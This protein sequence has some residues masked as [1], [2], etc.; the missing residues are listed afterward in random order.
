MR[1]LSLLKKL[2]LTEQREIKPMDQGEDSG[3]RV[4]GFC[5]TAFDSAYHGF[6]LLNK[7]LHHRHAL[8]KGLPDHSLVVRVNIALLSSGDA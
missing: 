6:H 3:A 2:L 1:K 8:I 4:S 7:N 5:V